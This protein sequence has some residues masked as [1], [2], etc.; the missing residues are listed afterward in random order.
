MRARGKISQ[1][2]LVDVRVEGSRSIKG[3]VSVALDIMRRF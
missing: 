2:Y 3:V 1:I